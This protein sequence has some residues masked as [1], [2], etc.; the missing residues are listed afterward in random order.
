MTY[1]CAKFGQ[2]SGKLAVLA[3]S[4]CLR[5]HLSQLYV[6]ALTL[7]CGPRILIQP[8][9]FT[10]WFNWAITNNKHCVVKGIGITAWFIIDTCKHNNYELTL[11]PESALVTIHTKYFNSK[12]VCILLDECMCTMILGVNSNYFPNINWLVCKTYFIRIIYTLFRWT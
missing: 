3:I 2:T 12:K 10:A 9:I 6:A 7:V 4:Q 11:A 1:C 8:I 5:L